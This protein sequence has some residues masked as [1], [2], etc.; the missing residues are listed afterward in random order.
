MTSASGGGVWTAGGDT[1]VST[2]SRGRLSA[3]LL[4]DQDVADRAEPRCTL[5]DSCRAGG[6]RRL[7]GPQPRQALPP[8]PRETPRPPSCPPPRAGAQAASPSPS[9]WSGQAGLASSCSGKT[10]VAHAFRSSPA[11]VQCLQV[12]PGNSRHKHGLLASETSSA[13]KKL[14]RVSEKIRF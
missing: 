11:R 6:R 3:R 9:T 14:G 13:S 10:A 8:K 12:L 1:P 5:R 4:G 7:R 2:P